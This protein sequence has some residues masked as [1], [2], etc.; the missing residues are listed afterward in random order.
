MLKNIKKLRSQKGFTLV[1]ISIVLVIIGLIVSGVLVG[2]ELVKNAEIRSLITQ[3]EG[4][5]TASYTFKDK[6]RTLPGDFAN[7]VNMLGA[8]ANGDGNGLVHD[9]A[10]TPAAAATTIVGEIVGFWQHLN[11]AGLAE[12][13]YSGLSAG[14]TALNGGGQNFPTMKGNNSAGILVYSTPER[15]NY[16]HIGI[17][18]DTTTTITTGGAMRPDGA[19]NLDQKIDD[20]RADAGN[21]R[22]MG[23][24]ETAPSDGATGSPGCVIT[25][26][27][28]AYNAANTTG[29]DCQLRVRM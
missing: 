22:A 11:L 24:I 27:L 6:Y 25:T 4:Y 20:G 2:Q 3:I 13:A 21:V 8:A 15:V 1:E 19:Y 12:T 18:G 28:D 7:A 17:I 5:N 29:T 26:A 9:A 10:G 23:G 14:G 16:Y